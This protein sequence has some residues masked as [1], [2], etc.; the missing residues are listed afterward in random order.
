[1]K[2]ATSLQPFFPALTE[3]TK[4]EQPI[5]RLI[6]RLLTNTHAGNTRT[7]KQIH[8]KLTSLGYTIKPYRFNK[9]IRTLRYEN[10]FIIA[11]SRGYWKARK[12]E[13]LSMYLESLNK[14]AKSYTTLANVMGKNY[15]VEYRKNGRVNGFID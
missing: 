4:E 8:E 15:K 1:M 10:T 6:K 13:E 3:L 5:K 2:T 12:R 11:D 7:A 9:I 14:R